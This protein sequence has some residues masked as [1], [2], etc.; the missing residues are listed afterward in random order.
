MI[1]R[2]QLLKLIDKARRTEEQLAGLY[3]SHCL[4]FLNLLGG[5][6]PKREEL[7]STFH[8]LRDDSRRHR[9]ELDGLRRAIGT[10]E[11]RNAY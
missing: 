4:L 11:D 10:R 7:Q 5:D 9:D 2:R 3:A 1:R 6:H 8:R